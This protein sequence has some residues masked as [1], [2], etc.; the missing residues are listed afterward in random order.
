MFA[1]ALATL[2]ILCNSYSLITAYS[3]TTVWRFCIYMQYIQ[4]HSPLSDIP[5]DWRLSSVCSYE[6]HEDI[7]ALELCSMPNT[8]V[9]ASRNHHSVFRLVKEQHTEVVFVWL[10]SLSVISSS[11]V[12]FAANDRT[13]FFF[14]LNNVVMYVQ[15]TLFVVHLMLV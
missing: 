11:S 13:S 4:Q 5:Y 15:H 6:T 2:T 7:R 3:G 8:H 9:C 1:V 14:M 10:F 12:H